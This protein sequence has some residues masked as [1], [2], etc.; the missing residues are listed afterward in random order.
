MNR[1]SFW[2]DRKR[3]AGILS[4]L[5]GSSMLL[6]LAFT[7]AGTSF[8]HVSMSNRMHNDQS[9]KNLAEAAIAKAIQKLM[10]D[11][12]RYQPA[13]AGDNVPIGAAPEAHGFL[14]FDPTEAAAFNANLKQVRLEASV[15]NF[16]NQSSK[17]AGSRT[18]PAESVY[19]RAVGVDHGVEKCVE[20]V[21]YIP[22]FPWAVASEGKI[23]GRDTYVASVK[24]WADSDDPALHKPGHLVTNASGLADAVKFDGNVTVTGDVQSRSGADFGDATI[25][26]E[27]RLNADAVQIPEIDTAVYNTAARATGDNVFDDSNPPTSGRPIQGEAYGRTSLYSSGIKL[28][29][30]ILY[31][32]GSL[33]LTGPLEGEGAII[34]TGDISIT[35]TGSLSSNNK[36]ALVSDGDVSIQGVGTDKMELSGMIYSEGALTIDNARIK[37]NVLAATDG[38]SM[39]LTDTELISGSEKFEITLKTPG[40]TGGATTLFTA[41]RGLRTNGV[42]QTT[43]VVTRN[44]KINPA[45]PLSPPN[46]QTVTLNLDLTSNIDPTIDPSRFKDPATGKYEIVRNMG[47][48]ARD[49]SGASLPAGLYT[50]RFDG[51]TY[52]EIPPTTTVAPLTASMLNVTIGGVVTSGADPALLTKVQTY[53]RQR[54]EAQ[55]GRP[56]EPIEVS[57]L[58]SAMS[59]YVTDLPTTSSLQEAAWNLEESQAGTT[60][61]GSTTVLR[62]EDFSPNKFLDRANKIRVLY[63]REVP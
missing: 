46:V 5:V 2:R 47:H 1:A 40:T 3:G 4:V 20:A 32:D 50:S 43:T 10:I 38:S 37:G 59:G 9:A 25:R 24:D 22:Q 53:A 34:A 8:H 57:G 48:G 54:L 15:N 23:V 16:G 56:L 41:P 18:L 51:T 17:P 49:Q 14:T 27:R 33:T 58:N 55:L 35:G 30:G 12:T 19:L 63:W 28:D 36:V 26:G 62:T 44:V 11:H 7:V 13:A 6:L 42:G 29:G 52:Y 31:V 61:G 45:G 60:G 21:L 39:T